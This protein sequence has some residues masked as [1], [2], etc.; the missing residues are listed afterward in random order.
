MPAEYANITADEMTEFLIPQGFSLIELP[1]TRELVFGKRVDLEDL[2]LSLRIYTGIEPTGASREV[3][4][5]AIRA[6][7][8]WRRPDGEVR[9][10]AS[11]KR[12]HRVKGWK[13]NLAKRLAELKIEKR[14][15]VCGAPMVKR[16]VFKNQKDE[17]YGC[18]SYPDC[19]HTEAI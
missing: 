2:T 11:S 14:C 12:V 8:F 7:I 13:D 18:A 5:D 4:S 16:K 3:G 19:K 1:N 9:K 6:N 10:V 17:F 15:S